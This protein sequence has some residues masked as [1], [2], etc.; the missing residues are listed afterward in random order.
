MTI[1]KVDESF[2]E[3]TGRKMGNISQ[4]RLFNILR[5]HDSTKFM[6]IWRSFSLSQYITTDV[7]FYDSYEVGSDMWWDNISYEIYGTPHLWWIV[8]LMNN[9]VN[10]FEELEEG[11]NIKILREEYLYVL[12]KD[13]EKI[14]DLG[15]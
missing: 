4:L 12:F 2:Y 5:D 15:T 8:A 9:V 1:T 7:T 10:P 6:N 14:S 3:L 11:T 13:I